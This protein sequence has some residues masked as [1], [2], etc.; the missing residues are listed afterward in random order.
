MPTKTLIAFTGG[1][2]STLILWKLLNETDDEITAV[3][4]DS[5]FVK[6]DI[7]TIKEYVQF[8]R[9]Q[10]VVDELRK[11]R[12]FEFI[13]YKIKPSDIT[14]ELY[15]KYLQFVQYAA[16]FI[17]NGT[18][19]KLVHGASYEDV[20]CKVIPHLE[21]FPTYYVVERLFNRLCTRG[22]LYEPLIKD[23]TWYQNYTRAYAMKELPSSIKTTIASCDIPKYDNDVKDFVDC[24]ECRKCLENK[25]VSNMLN[26]GKTPEE[27]FQW[28]MQKNREYGTDKLM[29]PLPFW[30]RKEAGLDSVTPDKEV[31]TNILNHPMFKNIDKLTGVW[32][33]IHKPIE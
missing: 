22:E 11:I 17:N 27:I 9:A 2:D 25:L 29:A 31:V 10:K 20:S 26:E 12:N 33:G 4:L 18:Y 5:Q 8:I 19:D 6:T 30:I 16:P 14:E 15:L 21:Y 23:K 1:W 32:E 24:G 28:R 7:G 13:P 3:Y